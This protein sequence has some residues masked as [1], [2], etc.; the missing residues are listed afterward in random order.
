M[1]S[2]QLR[3]LC[4]WRVI[5]IFALESFLEKDREGSLIFYSGLTC[6]ELRRK[7]F[8]RS[9]MSNSLWPHELQH[10][11]PP[12]HHQLPE[13]TQTHVHWVSDA[14]QL[15]H[16]LSS[17]SPPA[18][19]LSQHQGL[20][21]WVHFSI[22]WSNLW[23]FSFSIRRSSEYSGLISFKIDWVDLLAVQDTFKSLFQHHSSKESIL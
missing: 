10:A 16:P 7:R 13:F 6:K 14:I 8:S 1:L 2:L 17:P 19:N 20:F 5:G 3:A 18:F 12:C 15:S 4:F 11:R 9:V 23:S 21:Q 22:R